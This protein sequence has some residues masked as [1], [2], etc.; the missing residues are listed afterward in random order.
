MT[1]K[2]S[3]KIIAA[4][5]VIILI[6]AAVGIYLYAGMEEDDEKPEEEDETTYFEIQY[7]EVS[8]PATPDNQ[9]Y[10]IKPRI[11]NTRPYVG[12]V[13]ISQKNLKSVNVFVEYS[14]NKVGLFPRIG[15]LSFIGRD[16]ITITIYDSQENELARESI[17]GRGNVSIPVKTGGDMISLEPI[18]AEDLTE[19]EILLEERYIDY[20]ESYTIRISLRTGLWGKIREILG[21]DRFMLDVEYTFYNYYIEEMIPGDDFDDEFP[22]TGEDLGSQTW[23]PMAYPGKS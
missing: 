5:G 12:V 20:E 17:S 10:F 23:A 6:V 14:D 21:R 9:D 1:L 7:D 13:D 22:P 19:A 4:I 3:D 15:F 8:M 2:K 18:E 11:L 16:T